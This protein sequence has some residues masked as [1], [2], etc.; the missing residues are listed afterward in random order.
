VA[1]AAMT[2]SLASYARTS[3]A[4]LMIAL[5]GA[6]SLT[7]RWPTSAWLNSPH[8]KGIL[9]LPSAQITRIEV[10]TGA[11]N[12]IVFEHRPT[13]EWLVNGCDAEPAIAQH[14]DIAL[15]MLN[16]S[17]P[18]RTLARNEY[19][20]AQVVDFGLDPPRMLVSVF[21]SDG[22]ATSL[23]FGEPTPAQNAQYVRLIGRPNLY[24]L[25]RYVG[26]EWQVALDMVERAAPSQAVSGETTPG[27]SV[28]LLPVS[29]TTIWAVEIVDKGALTRFERDPA[30]DWFPHIGQHTHSGPGAIVHKADPLL[31]PL[32]AAELAALERL[33]VETVLAKHPDEAALAQFGL[34]HPSSIMLLY[35]RDSSS[36]VAHVSF[37]NMVGDGLYRY[38]RV[39][40]REAVVATPGYATDHIT[41]LLQ[42]S[43]VRS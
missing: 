9:N 23:A 29:M 3:A 35:T 11:K 36:P 31:A 16:V 28:L 12:V 18:L 41:K 30:G 19:T 8:P 37:G 14:V 17:N 1:E 21:G 6:V 26:V 43:G 40:E 10:S 13:G 25:Q 39:Q 42:L 22:A 33:S 7:G 38:A 34:E 15:R 5:L 24:L 27:S 32:I 20:S 2:H 4:V